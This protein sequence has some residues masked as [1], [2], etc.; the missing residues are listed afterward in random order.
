M[1]LLTGATGY[2]GSHI[3]IELLK[4]AFKV[5]GIDNLSNSSLESLHSIADISGQ[6]PAFIQG[7]IRD[8]EFL[9]DIFLKHSISHVVH[10]AA[11]KDSKESMSMR[12]YYFDVN[13][14]GLEN[15]LKVMRAYDC[16]KIIFSS[17]AAVYGEDAISPVSEA[18]IP[19]PSNYYGE[20]KLAGER[21]LAE[22]FNRTPTISSVS[23]RYFNVAGWHPSGLLSEYAASKSHSLF[24]EIQN[25]IQGKKDNL[26]IFGDDWNTR[27]GTPIRDYLHVSDLANGHLDAIRLLDVTD[28]L[29]TL[30]L[31]LGIGQSVFDVISAYEHISVRSIPIKVVSRRVGDVGVSFADIS[32]ATRVINW[33]PKKTLSDMCSD[34]F[35][36]C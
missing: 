29:F 7:D 34:S 24:S 13:V 12:S 27:D 23:L 30:N 35:R 31:G 26:S 4:G 2:I 33:Q 21:L 16:R 20:T 10:L 28:G 15:L 22:E 36:S 14:L 9:T 11:L 32:E 19:N 25:V 1:I 6:T 5:V 8:E 18:S 17:S 3:W